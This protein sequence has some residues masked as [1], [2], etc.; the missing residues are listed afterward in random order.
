MNYSVLVRFVL[1]GSIWG[2][3]FLF[4]RIVAPV[5]GGFWT[6]DL[7]LFIGVICPRIDGHQL[8]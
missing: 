4:M 2:G 3:S 7:R 5:I 6:A 8:T 1:L